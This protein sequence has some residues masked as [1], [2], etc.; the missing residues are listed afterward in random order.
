M[1]FNLAAAFIASTTASCGGNMFIL[2]RHV[3]KN[4][5]KISVAYKSNKCNK[6]KA[7]YPD[8]SRHI[9]WNAVLLDVASNAAPILVTLQRKIQKY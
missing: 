5:S 2:I 3:C 7:E 1:T 6:I 4:A 8:L 9:N